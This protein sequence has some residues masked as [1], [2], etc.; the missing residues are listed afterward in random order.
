M[1]SPRQTAANRA[2]ARRSTGPRTAAG[3]ARSSRNATRHGLSVSALADPRL[4][5]EVLALAHAIAAAGGSFEAAVVAAE[6]TFALRRIRDHRHHLLASALAGLTLTPAA[7]E[8]AASAD[9]GV[10]ATATSCVGDGDDGA[11][12]KASGAAEA[13]GERE[14]GAVQQLALELR[15][16][17]RY[18]RR[19]LSRR[20]SAIRRLAVARPGSSLAQSP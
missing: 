3:R 12:L 19:A 20:T 11:E 17:D 15:R 6:A 7:K 13:D 2:N 1:T 16:L 8:C 5:N 14:A 9:A 18:E 10:L 4:S